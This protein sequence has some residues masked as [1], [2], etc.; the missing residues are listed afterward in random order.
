M[1]VDTKFPSINDGSEK[2]YFKGHCQAV[3]ASLQKAKTCL[4]INGNQK[5]MIAAL[6]CV[7]LLRMTRMEMD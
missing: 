7:A 4:S 3:E 2:M 1:Y 6:Y 5:M